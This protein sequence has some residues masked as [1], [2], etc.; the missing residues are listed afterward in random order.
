[1]LFQPSRAL[2]FPPIAAKLESGMRIETMKT[3]RVL[4]LSA[5]PLLSEGLANLLSRIEDLLLI[6]PRAVSDFAVSDLNECRPDVVLL[7]GQEMEDASVNTLL[8]QILQHVPDLPVIQIDLSG[9][10]IVRV[11]T[12]HTRP[13]RSADL[14]DTIRSL[15]FDCLDS[16]ADETNFEEKNL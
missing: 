15:P 6:G 16:A 5:H 3:Y 11:Y 1:M 2:H 12:S 10:N 8:L 13:A 7:A 14:I 9:K 4:L